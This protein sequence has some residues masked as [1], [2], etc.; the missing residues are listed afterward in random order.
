MQFC[1]WVS[2]LD[3][4]VDSHKIKSYLGHIFINASNCK[5]VIEVTTTTTAA[6]AAAV[7]TVIILI[8]II[9]LLLLVLLLLLTLY[10]IFGKSFLIKYRFCVH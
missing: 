2:A 6:T 3:S 9:L 7:V 8:I 5:Y 1:S 10:S 4:C